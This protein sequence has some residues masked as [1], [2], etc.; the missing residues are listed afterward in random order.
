MNKLFILMG[1]MGSLP[2]DASGQQ[3]QRNDNSY[4]QAVISRMRIL[5]GR[6]VNSII[7]NG[8]IYSLIDLPVYEDGVVNC[9][10]KV[11]LE[12]LKAKIS[13]GWL[14]P[15]APDK[16]KISCIH[17]AG[18]E[19]ARS[20]WYYTK[21]NYHDFIVSVVKTM[22]PTLSNLYY[23][24]GITAKVIGNVNYSTLSY[25]GEQLI[26]KDSEK[27][28]SF[29]DYKGKREHYLYKKSDGVYWLANFNVYA[30]GSVL[31]DGIDKSI[32]I[33]KVQELEPLIQHGIIATKVPDNS[34]IIIKDLGEFVVAKTL[35]SADVKDKFVEIGDIVSSLNGRPTTSGDCVNAFNEYNKQP[36]K[37]NKA[38]LKVAYER[39]P[40]HLRVYVLGDMDAKDWP[41][42]KVIYENE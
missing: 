22:N 34:T 2:D 36:T 8:G 25:S 28:I 18:W 9:W 27:N 24:N 5:E 11:D 32:K 19:I 40:K 39:I 12:E 30:D 35:Y 16:G 41:I 23:S 42:R 15:T 26:R 20:K 31:I 13:K 1:L 33:D 21:E 7:N 38:K 10:D 4:P 29:K 37:E 17:L 6:Y 3:A 14:S